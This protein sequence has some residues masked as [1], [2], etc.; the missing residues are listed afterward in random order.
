MPTVYVPAPAVPRE[1]TPDTQQVNFNNQLIRQTHDISSLIQSE[2]ESPD[3]RRKIVQLSK[4][5]HSVHS[6]LDLSPHMRKGSKVINEEQF[7][8]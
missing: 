1:S 4:M 6:S 8:S 2:Q 7:G 3:V 5:P